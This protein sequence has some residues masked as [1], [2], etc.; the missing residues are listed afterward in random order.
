VVLRAKHAVRLVGE[1]LA[2]ARTNHA[3]WIVP[4]MAILA[5]VAV[6][7]ATTHA[8]VPVAVYTLF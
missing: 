1:I 8:A 5:V 3:W 4:L 6:A 7:V 2:Y